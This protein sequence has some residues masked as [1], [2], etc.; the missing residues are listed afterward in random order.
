M[1][2]QSQGGVSSADIR[3]Y[4]DSL[5][6]LRITRYL[7]S[8]NL[9]RA[10]AG[11]IIRAQLLPTILLA[12]SSFSALITRRSTGSLT[13]SRLAGVL[14]RVPVEAEARILYESQEAR[15]DSYV[16]NHVFTMFSTYIDNVYSLGK[17]ELCAVRNL[18]RLED[19]LKSRWGLSLKEGEKFAMAPAGAPASELPEGWQSVQTIN[20]LGHAVQNSGRWDEDFNLWV[21]S[22]WRAF[23]G[24]PGSKKAK[25]LSPHRRVRML[26]S[27]VQPLLD[28]RCPVWPFVPGTASRIDRVHRKMLSCIQSPRPAPQEDAAAFI[29]RRGRLAREAQAATGKWGDRWQKR[30]RMWRDH[31]ERAAPNS[32]WAKTFLDWR[33]ADWVQQRRLAAGSSSALAGRTATRAAAGAPPRRWAE[34]VQSL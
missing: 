5:N 17:S 1:D 6:V 34:S 21:R 29:R 8:R 14:G 32:S 31:L 7:I 3:Q 9:P 4:Y 13:G 2:T 25:D 16:A 20:I 22:A 11:A 33:S 12:T 23:F 24:N 28:W 15:A 26:G 19:A 27:S 30:L 10:V 18:C